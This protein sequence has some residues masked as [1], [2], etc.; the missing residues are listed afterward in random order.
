MSVVIHSPPHQRSII[1]VHVAVVVAVVVALSLPTS[2]AILY[3]ADRID[4]VLCV[5]KL[6]PPQYIQEVRK[7]QWTCLSAQQRRRGDWAQLLQQQRLLDLVG[8][9]LDDD[10]RLVRG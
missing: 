7:L 5:Q 1:E 9:V 2:N 3:A 6:L 10:V 8:H 4:C